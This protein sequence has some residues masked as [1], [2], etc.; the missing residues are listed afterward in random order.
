[1]ILL[2]HAPLDEARK[3]A[4]QVPVFD[5]VVASGE[6]SLASNEL[7]KVAGTKTRLM[8]VGLKAMYVGIIGFFDDPQNRIR[9]E[10]V[11]LDARFA[12]S[13]DMLN[14]LAEYQD[15]LKELGLEGLS[16]KSQPHPS[17]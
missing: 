6:T 15:Q 2:A 1:L 12:D 14:L 7:E 13:P 11:P 10:S 3:L 4:E 17:G 5:L 9:Y 8:Q 16:I